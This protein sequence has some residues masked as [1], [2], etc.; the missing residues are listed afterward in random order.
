MS[1]LFRISSIPPQCLNSPRNTETCIGQQYKESLTRT[2]P[3]LPGACQL[4]KVEAVLVTY[5][6]NLISIINIPIPIYITQCPKS[7][8]LWH[9]LYLR[10]DTAK[11]TSIQIWTNPVLYQS[12]NFSKNVKIILYY[13]LFFAVVWILHNF[14]AYRYDLKSFVTDQLITKQSFSYVRLVCY[15]S[16]FSWLLF[17][18]LFHIFMYIL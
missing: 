10:L 1:F 12:T 2:D 3:V 5:S 17:I 14:V 8:S 11:Q 9:Y 16:F 18:S 6:N 4:T 7:I 13:S 15:N